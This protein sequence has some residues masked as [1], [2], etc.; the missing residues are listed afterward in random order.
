MPAAWRRSTSSRDSAHR[1][2]D[3]VAQSGRRV[4]LA[5]GPAMAGGAHPAIAPHTFSS[6]DVGALSAYVLRSNDMLDDNSVADRSGVPKVAR[7]KRN[8]FVWRA[9]LSDTHGEA[10]MTDRA[11]PARAR[12]GREWKVENATG[13]AAG[14]RDDMRTT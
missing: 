10:C 5:F 11:D 3:A 8:G 6:N 4:F 1:I 2:D 7:P 9:P 13:R 12:S 14:P